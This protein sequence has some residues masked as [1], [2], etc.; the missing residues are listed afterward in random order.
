MIINS[1]F[2]V[3]MIDRLVNEY[4]FRE[5]RY[6]SQLYRDRLDMRLETDSE[7]SIYDSL[8]NIGLDI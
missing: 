3:E 8:Y 5:I 2:T 4:L 6:S 1:K 7:T